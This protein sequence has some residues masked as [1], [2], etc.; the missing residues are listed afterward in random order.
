MSLRQD[1]VGLL[2][3]EG[4]ICIEFTVEAIL[5]QTEPDEALE[6]FYEEGLSIVI[7]GDRAP[8]S[9]VYVTLYREDG[10]DCNFQPLK[11]RLARA[12]RWILEN[13]NNV[14]AWYGD[15]LPK[16][17]VEFLNDIVKEGNNE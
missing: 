15:Y 5:W 14:A 4:D 16:L 10:S 13:Q 8:T 11:K 6:P 1:N 2:K 7:D 3:L 12:A 9:F 17:A